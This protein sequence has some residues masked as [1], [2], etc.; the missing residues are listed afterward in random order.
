MSARY[1][2]VFWFLFG[3]MIYGLFRYGWT[4]SFAWYDLIVLAGIAFV[5]RKME[6]GDQAI[7]AARD[8]GFDTRADGGA[9]RATRFGANPP[10]GPFVKL[11]DEEQIERDERHFQNDN[12]LAALRRDRLAAGYADPPGYP[13]DIKRGW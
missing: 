13:E 9:I 10:H 5:A 2:G 4:G 11:T 7:E 1:A 12:R 3:A 8:R 6:R